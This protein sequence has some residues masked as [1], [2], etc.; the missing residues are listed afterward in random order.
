VQDL[1]PNADSTRS[2]RDQPIA[3]LFSDS[4]NDTPC[5]FIDH[6]RE[7]WLAT[8]M[9]A[10]Y[11]ESSVD[12][13]VV[14]DKNNLVGTVG[15]YDLLA[16]VR[17]CPTR[18]FQYESKVENIMFSP[19][20]IIDKSIKFRDLMEKWKHS[21]RAFSIYRIG[22]DSNWFSISARK[23]LQIG[24]KVPAN[25]STLSIQKNKIVTFRIDD[26]IGEILDL[27]Y[28]NMTRKLLLE[29]SNQFISDR[30]VL[31]EI[32]RILKFEENVEDILDFPISHTRLEYVAS[33]NTDLKL[34]ELCSIINK[35]D[36]PYLMYK[37][38]V[39]T[40]WDICLVL[41]SEDLQVQQE[42]V[43]VCPCCGRQIESSS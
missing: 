11:T 39:V 18:K 27:M 37:D 26:T 15:G 6:D 24:M 33:I 29:N 13:I 16:Y 38:T 28:K 35:S 42:Q 17:K 2:I 30:I 43:G 10:E 7:V 25:F 3:S 23:M 22:F 21:R 5:V 19:V 36:H 32:S 4:L 31:G 1:D 40:P 9:C 34:G 8:E 41:L 12:Q 14:L 20:P